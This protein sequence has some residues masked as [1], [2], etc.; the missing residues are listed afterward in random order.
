VTVTGL[1]LSLLGILVYN[2]MEFQYA[3]E[4]DCS[5]LSLKLSQYKYAN[6]FKT[7]YINYQMISLASDNALHS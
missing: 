2:N 4:L 6:L 5:N 1:H 3:M 7:I